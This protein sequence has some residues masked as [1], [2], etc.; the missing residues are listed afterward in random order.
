[1]QEVQTIVNEQ[2]AK[3]DETKNQFANVASGIEESREETNGIKSQTEICD[4][5]RVSVVDIISNLSAIS[6]ENAASS[7]ETTASMA[8]L[9]ST[10]GALADSAEQLQRISEVLEEEMKFFKL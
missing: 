3:L 4:S 6:E 1:M 9:S 8:E 7:E 5:A 10:I 2:K